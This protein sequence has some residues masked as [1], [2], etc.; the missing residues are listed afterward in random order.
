MAIEFYNVNSGEKR[1]VDTEPLIAAFYNSG[2][3]HANANVGQD[4]GW[5]LSPATIKR[6]REIKKDPNTLER[7]RSR[8][9]LTQDGITD[10]DILRYISEEDA[11]KESQQTEVEEGAFARQYEDEVRALDQEDKVKNDPNPSQPAG[12]DKT[13]TRDEQYTVEEIEESNPVTSAEAAQQPAQSDNL[14]D[15]PLA[16][17][18]VKK[19]NK[20]NTGK[21]S[22]NK[23]AK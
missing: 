12:A 18:P 3:Q 5:R 15:K 21:K 2:D 22:G 11:R 13:E 17:T 7:L 16:Q 14:D 1:T 20:S 8:Y 19:D 6:I 23:S 4:F 9:S 10:T